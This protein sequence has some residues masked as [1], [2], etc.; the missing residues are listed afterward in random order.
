MVSAKRRVAIRGCGGSAVSV[1]SRSLPCLL[2]VEINDPDN[3]EVRGALLG[4]EATGDFLPQFSSSA[5]HARRRLLVNGTLGS[6]RKRSIVRFARAEPQQQIVADPAWRWAAHGMAFV[7]AGC[8]VM[9][10]GQPVRD[11]GIVAALD[12]RDH[13][14][15]ERQVP[16]RVRGSLHGKPGAA[17]AASVAPNLPFRSRPAPS[18]RADGARCGAGIVASGRRGCNVLGTSCWT[19]HSR[20]ELRV[21]IPA[22][23]VILAGKPLK[24]ISLRNIVPGEVRSITADAAKRSVLVETALAEMAP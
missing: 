14:R 18:V 15:P 3:G 4:A 20:A 9:A 10:I 16:A 21:R 24:A 1:W 13:L 6:V 12:Q 11:D 17:A 2:A 22:R 8:A 23:E 7:K 5:R 19:H